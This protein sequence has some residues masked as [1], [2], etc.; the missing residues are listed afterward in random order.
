MKRNELKKRLLALALAGAMCAG[1]PGTGMIALAEEN[2]TEAADAQSAELGIKYADLLKID[3]MDNDVKLITDADGNEKL[4]V[5]RDAEIPEGYEDKEVLRTP[6]EHAMFGSTTHVGLLSALEDDS[7]YDSIAAVTTEL[8]YW[9]VPEVIER[10]ESGQI[11]YIAQDHWTAGNMEDITTV[12]PDVVLISGGDEAAVQLSAQLDEVNIPYII[13]SEWMETTSE[14]KLEWMKLFGALYNEDQQATDIF[15]RKLAR[16]AELKE[17]AAAIP[18][19]DKPVVA[20]GMIYDG[21]VYTQG[22]DSPTAK[23]IEDA[24]GVYALKDLE[25]E[26]SV[27]IG[28]EEFVDKAKDADI[29]IYSSQISYTPDKAYVE[30]LEPLITEFKAYQNDT[31]YVYSAD[32]YMCSAAVD[33]KFED[34]VAIIHPEMMEGYELLHAVKLPDVAE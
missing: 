3:Y 5:P 7:L 20:L 25:G 18:D 33:E 14:G 11:T 19:E 28:M 32:Y 34:L 30:D 21:I 1:L 27:Q 22:G 6:I 8:E 31:M 17:E 24:G 15:E 4:L 12:N 10:M 16:V 13:V 23:E 26:G 2:A 9:T 29:L